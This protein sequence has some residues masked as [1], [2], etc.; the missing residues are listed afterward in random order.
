MAALAIEILP[1]ANAGNTDD[2]DLVG[3]FIDDSIAPDSDS[4]VVF[5][6]NK[7]SA[8]G[9]PGIFSECSDR[10]RQLWTNFGG[11]P[12]EVVFR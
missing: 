11:D 8:T 12:I 2:A 6:T 10:S 3:D 1:V 4:P 9:W 7:L 5:R